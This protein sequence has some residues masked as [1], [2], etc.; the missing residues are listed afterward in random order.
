MSSSLRL[1]NA[2]TDSFRFP[3]SAKYLDVLSKNYVPKEHHDLSK[4]TQVLSTGSPLTAQL[5][6]WVYDNIGEN[7]ILGSISG[8]TDICSLFAA[9]NVSLPV[10]AGEIQCIALGMAVEAWSEDGKAVADG[11]PG[12]L[13]CV[14]PFPCMPVS[15]FGDEGGVRYHASYFEKFGE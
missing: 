8:G 2:S 14:K 15:F 7:L 6:K 11:E 4:I 13:V 5:Y 9:H 3:K 12:E 1:E 10:Y